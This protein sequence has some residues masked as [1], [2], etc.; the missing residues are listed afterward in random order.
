MR[1][2]FALVVLALWAPAPVLAG[3][4]HDSGYDWAES[5]GID[6]D[7]DCYSSQPGR[8][9]GDNI[10]NSPSFTEGCLE[11]V[12]E[13]E[14]DEDEHEDEDEDEDEDGDEY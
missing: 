9:A 10:N 2:L 3:E 1:C 6:D 12:E 5:E 13:T 4:G 14:E 11:Y 8:W 7:S